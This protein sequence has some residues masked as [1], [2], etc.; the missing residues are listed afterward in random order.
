VTSAPIAQQQDLAQLGFQRARHLATSTPA[1]QRPSTTAALLKLPSSATW[2]KY[3]ICFQM[4][5][6]DVATS[7]ADLLYSS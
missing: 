1:G 5:R 4:H 6:I 2:M 3:S 7:Y